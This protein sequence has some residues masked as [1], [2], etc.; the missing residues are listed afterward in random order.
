MGLRRPDN[1][2]TLILV[3]VLLM[4][5]GGYCVYAGVHAIL[6]GQEIALP[7]ITGHGLPLNGF[8]A[9]VAGAADV[10]FMVLI[11]WKLLSLPHSEP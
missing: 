11:I 8:E 1:F 3:A 2:A 10:L 7:S 4:A 6:I 9:V 5:V